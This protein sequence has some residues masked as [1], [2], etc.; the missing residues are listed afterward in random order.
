MQHR[1]PDDGQPMNDEESRWPRVCS[2]WFFQALCVFLDATGCSFWQLHS[3]TDWL[4]PSLHIYFSIYFPLRSFMDERQQRRGRRTE[5]ETLL[6]TSSDSFQPQR[7]MNHERISRTGTRSSRNTARN[8]S[9]SHFAL[10]MNWAGGRWLLSHFSL[11]NIN[12]DEKWEAASCFSPHMQVDSFLLQKTR[13]TSAD[14]R[15]DL[16]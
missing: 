11:M 9:L 1:S 13:N 14:L 2:R 3:Q 7:L 12:V 5:S 15:F 16:L 4:H 8:S 6:Q 10:S